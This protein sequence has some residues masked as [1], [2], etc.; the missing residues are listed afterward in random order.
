MSL[1]QIVK[2]ST[3]LLLR[4]DWREFYL[5]TLIALGRVDLETVTIDKLN[6][7]PE[8]AHSYSD[9][10]REDLQKVLAALEIRQGDA[11]VDFG[12][13][14]GG[15][16][17]TL[18]EYDFS[19]ITG[20]EISAALTG[21]ARKNLSR[22][23]IDNVEVVCCDAGKFTDLDAY[24]YCYFFNPFPGAV[25][26]EV[27]QNLARSLNR[28]PR[29]MTI[30]YLNPECHDRIIEHGVFRKVAEFNHASH[31]FFVYSNDPESSNR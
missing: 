12:C 11:V 5:R 25:M 24:N 18:A 26:T 20:I 2:T 17:I 15:A 16:L 21:I 29:K 22:L 27:L 31:V 3:S 28:R 23:K 6:L 13:G 7:S 30:I 1:L 19:K 8:Q 14:K 10:G 9:S 4:G